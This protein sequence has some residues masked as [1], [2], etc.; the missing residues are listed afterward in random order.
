MAAASQFVLPWASTVT[1]QPQA[2]SDEVRTIFVLGFPPDVKERELQNLLRWWPGYEASQMSMKGEQPMGFAL[3]SSASMAMAARDALQNLVF[4]PDL[5]SVLRAEMAKKNLYVKRGVVGN[6]TESASSFD[7][8]K[9]LRTAGAFVSAG[10]YAAPAPTYVTPTPTLMQ[11]TPNWAPQSFLP[12]VPAVGGYDPYSSF[13]LPTVPNPIAQQY[14]PLVRAV[15]A[16]G[17]AKDNPP[18]NTLFIGNLGEN[19]SEAELRGLFAGHRGYRQMKVLPQGKTKVCFV[20]MQDIPTAQAVHAAM[21]GLMLTTSDRGAIRVQFSKN[22]FGR[23]RDGSHG[24]HSSA[25]A[26][27]NKEDGA[28]AAA[29]AAAAAAAGVL[30][31]TSENAVPVETAGN[32]AV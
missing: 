24:G 27:G 9:R 7:P 19:T 30:A 10:T 3:F 22:P 11:T 26:D 1:P 5:N 13:Q 6:P 15:S 16:P 21:Q 28:A 23:K 25:A 20:E 14:A 32:G 4:D 18:C 2:D 29:R 17:G 12:Q 8:N 31:V